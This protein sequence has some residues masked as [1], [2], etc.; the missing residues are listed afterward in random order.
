MNCFLISWRTMEV[1]FQIQEL[2][3][4]VSIRNA[5]LRITG[6]T[7]FTAMQDALIRKVPAKWTMNSSEESF[8][9]RPVLM[10]LPRWMFSKWWTTSILIKEKNW[11]I[12]A[13]TKRSAFYTEKRS[14]LNLVAARL[15]P[16]TYVWNLS[17]SKNKL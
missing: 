6:Q 3:S 2:L 4:I 16:R 15:M 9:K 12:V 11:T 13:H 14:W 17:F 5:E 10:I 7:S 1:N 8:Q